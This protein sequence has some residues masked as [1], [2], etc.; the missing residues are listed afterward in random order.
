[1]N[2]NAGM[3]AVVFPIAPPMIDLTVSE[4]L[5]SNEKIYAENNERVPRYS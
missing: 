3:M 1:M 5:P 4:R 2:F